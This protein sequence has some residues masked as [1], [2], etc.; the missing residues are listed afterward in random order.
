[1]NRKKLQQAVQTAPRPAGWIEKFESA[2]TAAAAITRSRWLISWTS[3]FFRPEQAAQE[4]QK[5]ASIKAVALNLLL[6]YFGFFLLFFI[7][8]FASSLLS[9]QSQQATSPLSAELV[10]GALIINPIMNTAV[11]LFT[12]LLVHA[13]AR[14]LGGKATYAAQSLAIS[15]VFAGWMSILAFFMVIVGV[16]LLIASQFPAYTQLGAA[17]SI[18]SGIL[19]LL[20][21]LLA[22]VVFLSGFYKIWLAIRAAH[23]LSSLRAAAVLLLTAAV[24]VLLNT[25]LIQLVGP[26]PK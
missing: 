24:V 14:L 17:V 23:S 8:F 6:F 22:F 21:L 7:M 26:A 20:L 11:M 16:L 13:S 12:L 25:L 19:I 2:I 9:G 15:Q 10:L 4:A 5:E 18:I 3:A 1:M